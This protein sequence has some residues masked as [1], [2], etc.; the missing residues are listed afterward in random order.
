MSLATGAAS[1]IDGL[2]LLRHRGARRYVWAPMAAAALVV[3][4]LVVYGYRQAEALLGWALGALPSWLDWLVVVLWPV[5]ALL[6]IIIASWLFGLVAAVVASPW[7]GLLA[8][9]AERIEFGDAVE[10]S[11]GFA[12][13]I[14][15]ACRRELQKLRYHLPRLTALLLLPLLPVVNLVAPLL[16]LVFGAWLLALQFVDYAAENRGLPFAATRTSLAEHRA[17]ALGF[18]AL[19][20]LA[21]AVPLAALVVVPAAVCGGAVLWRRLH[22]QEGAGTSGRTG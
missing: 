15:N 17:A 12:A 6:A 13:L 20:A 4:P 19:A 11:E 22:P 1:F 18:G 9:Q 5:A 10:A 8:A 3:L 16:W 14:G 2:R 7:L 21:L